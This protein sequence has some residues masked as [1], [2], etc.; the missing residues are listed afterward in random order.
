MTIVCSGWLVCSRAG[1]TGETII[2]HLELSCVGFGYSGCESFDFGDTALIANTIDITCTS[3]AANYPCERM[4]VN[5]VV[6]KYF[7]I[8]STSIGAFR[9]LFANITVCTCMTAVVRTVSLFVSGSQCGYHNHCARWAGVV[10]LAF[11]S[12]YECYSG[13]VR[14]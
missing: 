12:R 1:F 8:T 13:Q 7:K 4:I 3:I 5:A 14:K 9:N 10:H 2:D 11:W 6:A